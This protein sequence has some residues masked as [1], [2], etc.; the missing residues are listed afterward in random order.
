MGP[1]CPMFSENTLMLYQQYLQLGSYFF[2]F[3]FGGGGGG[4]GGLRSQPW[5]KCG[6]GSQTNK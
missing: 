1:G 3:F 5:D 2:F 6:N 4:G